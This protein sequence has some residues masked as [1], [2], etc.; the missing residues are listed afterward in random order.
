MARVKIKLTESQMR[1]LIE[2]SRIDFLKNQFGFISN[3]EWEQLSKKDLSKVKSKKSDDPTKK[4]KIE[5]LLDDEGNLLALVLVQESVYENPETGKKEVNKKFKLRVSESVFDNVI[6]ADPTDKKIYVQWLLKTF[7]NL[8]KENEIDEAIRFVDEDLPQAN[9]YLK[10]FDQVKNTKLFTQTSE[11]NPN[12]PNNPT[13]INQYTNL[14]QLYAAVDPFIEK[15]MGQLE[16]DIVKYVK[17]SRAKLLYQD[18]NWMVYQPLD[19]DANCVMTSYAEWCTARPGNSMF[20]SYTKNNKEPDGSNSKIYVIINKDVLKGTSREVYQIH[21][22]SNQ[23]KDRTNGHNVDFYSFFSK[24]PKLADFFKKILTPLAKQSGGN[25]KTNKYVTKLMEMGEVDDIFDY[26]DPNSK[27]LNLSDIKLPKLPNKLG[28]F[29]NVEELYLNNCG[30]QELPD[31][32]GEMTNLQILL[33]KNNNIKTLPESIGNLKNLG[34]INLQGTEIKKFP[35]SFEK[36]SADE[37]GS[38]FRVTFTPGMLSDEELIRLKS[39]GVTT[40]ALK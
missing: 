1:L 31:S 38:L 8:I 9:D 18:S 6:N 39:M 16:S 19:R 37:G 7:T 21:F 32:I 27:T 2:N 3:E 36:L 17:A 15:E 29:K 5:P 14:S 10:T 12:L 30:L 13:D 34:I 22:E 24:H 11:N 35:K 33:L 20:D 23:F 26:I 40:N 25:L 4:Q 28:M